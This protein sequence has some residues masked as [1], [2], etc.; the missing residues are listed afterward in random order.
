MRAKKPKHHKAGRKDKGILIRVTAAQKREL[1][2]TAKRA[3]L[4]LSSWML[5][6]AL[7][8][9][10]DARWQEERRAKMRRA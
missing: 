1:A 8:A 9:A 6:I 2:S 4:G 3:G 5:T 7:V 10:Q